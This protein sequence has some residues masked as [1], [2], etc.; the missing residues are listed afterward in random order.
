MSYLKLD[1]NASE[2]QMVKLT[3]GGRKKH[4]YRIGGIWRKVRDKW[5]P[6]AW[7]KA[8]AKEDGLSYGGVKDGKVIINVDM[9]MRRRKIPTE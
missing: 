1:K 9:D 4:F 2:H 3:E 6:E 5:N 8:L 7:K